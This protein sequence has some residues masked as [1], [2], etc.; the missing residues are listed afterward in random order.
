MNLPK[1]SLSR[2]RFSLRFF[3][4]LL[5]G[6][7]VLT[8]VAEGGYYFWGQHSRTKSSIHQPVRQEDIFTYIKSP[9][10]KLEKQIFGVLKEIDGDELTI[11]TNSG[12]RIK[13][14]SETREIWI[15]KKITSGSSTEP[16]ARIGYLEELLPG[17]EVRLSEIEMDS[18]GALSA[19]GLII[20]K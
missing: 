19:R 15:I 6:L 11:L 17:D 8:L 2:P 14:K 10:E 5:F 4:Y 3:V 13:V 16:S 20:I 12:Q 18:K 7:I 1:I 9:R